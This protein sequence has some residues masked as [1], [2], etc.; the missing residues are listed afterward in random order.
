MG[1][2]L[3]RAGDEILPEDVKEKHQNVEVRSSDATI[4]KCI[5]L[6]FPTGFTFSI[7]IEDR[8]M[9]VEAKLRGNVVFFLDQIPASFIQDLKNL[10]R[11]F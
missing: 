11:E 6:R 7:R 3:K 9:I 1:L 10:L 2:Q 4:D 5:T 8:S